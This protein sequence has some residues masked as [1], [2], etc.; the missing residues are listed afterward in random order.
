M[1]VDS[2]AS[3]IFARPDYPTSTAVN[4]NKTRC[5]GSEINM[6][7]FKFA[8]YNPNDHIQFKSSL[9]LIMLVATKKKRLLS[10]RQ[11]S[12]E[13]IYSNAAVRPSFRNIIV[14]TIESTSF[15]GF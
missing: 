2:S 13:G 7:N 12:C 11:R 14:N 8:K 3:N 10:P 9:G 5:F 1:R 4:S 15:N 6:N